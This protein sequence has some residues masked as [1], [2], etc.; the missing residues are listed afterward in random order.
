VNRGGKKKVMFTKIFPNFGKKD[1]KVNTNDG[2]I[3]LDLTISELI[4]KDNSFIIYD[5]V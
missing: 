5:F 2:F 3:D 1:I 4:K